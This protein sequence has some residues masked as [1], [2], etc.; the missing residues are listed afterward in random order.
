MILCNRKIE[1]AILINICVFLLV[2]TSIY[3]RCI[4]DGGFSKGAEQIVVAVA[5]LPTG[6]YFVKINGAVI[7]KF[8]KE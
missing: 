5:E 4:G 2:I 7:R 3:L 8:L 6:M 1:F